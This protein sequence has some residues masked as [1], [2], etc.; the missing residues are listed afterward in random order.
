MNVNLE[1]FFK[2]SVNY[3]INKQLIKVIRYKVNIKINWYKIH[4]NKPIMFPPNIN[5]K[6]KT[7]HMYK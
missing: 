5:K 4:I 2:K 6:F 3:D 7:Y 1:K